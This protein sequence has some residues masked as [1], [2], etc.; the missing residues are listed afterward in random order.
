MIDVGDAYLKG[1]GVT[2]VSAEALKWYKKAIA[3]GAAAQGTYHISAMYDAGKGTPQTEALKKYWRK[4]ALTKFIIPFRERQQ[5]AFQSYQDRANSGN[6]Q[7]MYVLGNMYLDGKG[8]ERDGKKSIC[9]YQKAAAV[10]NVE[11]MYQVGVTYTWYNHHVKNHYERAMLYYQEAA[12]SGHA[13]AMYEIG[14]LYFQGFGVKQNRDTAV[15][16]WTRAAR[17]GSMEACNSLRFV[18]ELE[19]R[20]AQ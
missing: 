20:H 5:R 8:V 14:L 17:L 6:A 9:W 1:T 2:Q 4:R 10:G 3:N 11:A 15:I 19:S 12:I 18:K 7:A 16:W 13:N